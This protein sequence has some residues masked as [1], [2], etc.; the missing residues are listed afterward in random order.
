MRKNSRLIALIFVF[1][2][3]LAPLTFAQTNET[4]PYYL[5][6]TTFHRTGNPSVDFMEWKGVEKEYF[7]KVTSKN[8]LIINSGIYH[9]YFTADNTEL[10]LV[11]GYKNWND[12][13]KAGERTKAL[14]EEGWPNEKNRAA[15]FKKRASFYRGDHSDEIYKTLPYTVFQEEVG[16]EPTLLYIRKNKINLADERDDEIKEALFKEFFEEVIAKNSIL[17]GYHT[18]RHLW[19]ANSQDHIEVFVYDKFADIETSF[20]ETIKLTNEHWSDKE[21]REDFLKR[22]NKMF[23]GHGDYI[24][25]EVTELSK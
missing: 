16:S 7:E 6:V 22:Y 18:H 24:Y 21:K 2:I 9:H 10:I 25:Q 3:A 17:R 23:S 1:A 14:I 19:G 15:F 11:S 5:T 12:I 20:A 4:K 13:E 8:E